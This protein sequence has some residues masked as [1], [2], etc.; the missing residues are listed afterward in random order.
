MSTQ[1]PDLPNQPPAD[2]DSDGLVVL[3]V[4]NND[5]VRNVV[6]LAW[7]HHGFAVHL[8]ANGSTFSNSD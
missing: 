2:S 7:R 6:D 8:T 5:D 4:D 1:D 3:V